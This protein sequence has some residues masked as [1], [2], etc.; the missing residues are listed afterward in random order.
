[1]ATDLAGRQLANAGA[2]RPPVVPTREGGGLQKLHDARDEACASI[3]AV[4]QRMV[5]RGF[6]GRITVTVDNGVVRA[7]DV[8]IELRPS[9]K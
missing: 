7:Q 2:V 5:P 9:Q 1:M 6:R 4:L 8:A 3:A